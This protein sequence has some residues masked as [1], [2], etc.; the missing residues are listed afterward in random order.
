MMRN[1]LAMI[2]MPTLAA[3]MGACSTASDGATFGE[4]VAFLKE[5]VDVIVLSDP[6]GQAQVAL[7]PAYQ[8]RV[9]TSTSG[10]EKG[11]S[12]GWVNRKLIAS[13][14]FEPH[15][16][17]FGGEDRFWM[18]PEGGQFAIFF[19]KG[20]PFEYEHWQTPPAI[21][22]EPFEVVK[23]DATSAVFRRQATVS[24]WTGTTFDV[25]IDRVIRLLSAEDTAKALGR[26]V[27]NN[28]KAVAFESDNTITNTG[29]TAWTK[30]TGLLSIWILGMF[31]ASPDTTIV[32]PFEPGT[33]TERGIKVNDNYFGKVPPERLVVEDDV[34]FFN[35]DA[36]W[37][38]KIGLSPKR[39][40]SILGSYDAA[41]HVLT[42]VQFTLPKGA[43]E[44]VNSMWEM[45]E[46]PFAGDVSNSYNDG[47]LAPDGG[48]LGAF[49]EL[50]T[51]SPAAALAPNASISHLSRTIHLQGPEPD[52]DPIARAMLGVGLD[53]IKT[54]L[55]R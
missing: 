24:N 55:P 29:K 4:E 16:N 39:A 45:Q 12:Y 8:G 23:K 36:K 5:H 51:S 43:A 7:V 31:N 37:R 13:G 3:A 30:E 6:A 38:S 44:Y 42:L 22:T 10:G 21:D 34:L 53:K 25:R 11:L 2:T 15:I 41:N 40:K 28:V 27:S 54:A 14:K 48:Q 33:E 32:L 52:L 49:Y 18:G 47:P 50:E 19:P 26:P 9:I 1:M 35:G 20:A 17:V 46:H